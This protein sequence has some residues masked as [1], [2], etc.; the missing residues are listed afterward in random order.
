[1]RT[2]DLRYRC[3]DYSEVQVAESGLVPADSAF[4]SLRTLAVVSLPV[5]A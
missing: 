1:M 2:R 3:S 4:I 5:L